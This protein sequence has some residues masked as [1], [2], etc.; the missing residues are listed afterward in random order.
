MKFKIKPHNLGL[1]PPNTD[2]TWEYPLKPCRHYFVHFVMP[3]VEDRQVGSPVDLPYMQPLGEHFADVRQ[4]FEAI[5][6]WSCDQSLKAE[7]ALWALLW[8]MT[9]LEQA[10]PPELMVRPG[11]LETALG[12]IENELDGD[13]N[14]QV[15][16]RRIGI[17]YTHLNRLFKEELGETVSRYMAKQR[18]KQAEYLL[19]QS[20]LSIKAIAERVGMPNL[21]HFNKFIRH[22]CG[23]P[24]SVYRKSKSPAIK[25]DRKPRNRL[26]DGPED[27]T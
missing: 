22:H 17:S 1:T 18:F 20:N 9:D 16:A 6:R 24:P 7:V 19:C 14:A 26:T 3:E 25:S 21:Q 4:A 13:L 12:I 15:L 23:Q 11:H 5:L 8:K 10:E 27:R 2:L